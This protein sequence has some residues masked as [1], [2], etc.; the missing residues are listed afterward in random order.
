MGTEKIDSLA[1]DEIGVII[2]DAPEIFLHSG[3]DATGFDDVFT[4]RQFAGF[5][6]QQRRAALEQPLVHAAHGR[7]RGQ[8]G[9]GVGFAA[10]GAHAKLFDRE[11]LAG[12]FG[13][14]LD[15]F[16]GFA[17]GHLDGLE[18]AKAFNAEA[19]HGFASFP[20]FFDDA[21]SPLRLDANDH[22]GGDVRVAPDA[23]KRAEG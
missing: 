20:D 13:G 14:V 6:K 15:K 18:I 8:P 3:A 19:G 4:S 2:E 9:G 5:A 11:R 21:L 23:G 17:R 10:L 7:A 1:L 12:E 16:L 22:G